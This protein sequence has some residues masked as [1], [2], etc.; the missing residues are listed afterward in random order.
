MK[1]YII[2]FILLFGAGI[3]ISDID[4]FE[5]TATDSLSDIEGSTVAAGGASCETAVLTNTASTT[6]DW[7]ITDSTTYYF[8][9]HHFIDLGSTEDIC[10]ATFYI[11]QAT[12]DIS[13]KTYTAYIYTID[14]AGNLDSLL[15][16][17]SG[18]TG[19]N[20][21]SDTAVDFEFSPK[22]TMS[23]GTNHAVVVSTGSVDASN[24]AEMEISTS[25][26]IG[27]LS[28]RWESDGTRA[29]SSGNDV[30]IVLYTE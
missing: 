8:V 20:S 2:L 30:K 16:T 7:D 18:V 5:G 29:G 17:S 9:G 15:G 14:G 13:G 1:K 3:A 22:V 27:G 10:K 21:W 19:S 4:T 26:Q 11:T 24:Y 28:G 25:G 12:G 6:T 23:N